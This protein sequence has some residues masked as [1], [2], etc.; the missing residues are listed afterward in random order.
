MEPNLSIIL[1]LLEFVALLGGGGLVAVKL[2]QF[3]GRIE[4]SIALQSREISE[5]KANFDKLA[6]VFTQQAVQSHRILILERQ[7]QSLAQRVDCWLK[8]SHA[9][10]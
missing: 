2:G 3:S 1:R 4:T 6:D 9:N 7:I 10:T 8:D 5:L